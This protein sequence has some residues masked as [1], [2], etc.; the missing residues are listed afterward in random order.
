M[1]R[2]VLDEGY[3][4]RDEELIGQLPMRL[5]VVLIRREAGQ[6]PVRK[7]RE[8]QAI[9]ERLNHWTL[10]ELKGPTDVLERRDF[11]FLV[12]CAH[13]YCSQHAT[14][15][16]SRELTLIYVATGA[17]EAFWQAVDYR[18]C[19]HTKES[20]GVHRIEGLSF[21]AWLI[22]TDPV[23]GAGEPVL[24]LFSRVFLRDRRRIMEELMDSGSLDV[25]A[26]MSQ[27][28]QQFKLQGDQFMIQHAGTKVMHALE[29]DVRAFMEVFP[30][31]DR[32]RG[33]SPEERLEGLSPEERIKGLSAEDIKGLSPET[34]ERL[35]KLLD[36]Q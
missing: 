16:H 25:V 12:G 13:H 22:E 26:F 33:L 11:D 14:G 8:L 35:R 31:E 15:I 3:E 2:Y 17:N 34:L 32:L 28:I 21:E 1:L 24:T 20:E 7:A 5:D 30:V 9:F 19:T 10:I 23:S 6:V 18:N 36:R 27:Q 29:D 4:V